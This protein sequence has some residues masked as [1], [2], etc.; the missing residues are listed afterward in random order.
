MH[1]IN[2]G[3]GPE[4]LQGEPNEFEKA[5]LE[6][7]DLYDIEHNRCERNGIGPEQVYTLK[8][9]LAQ[10][11]GGGNRSRRRNGRKWDKFPICVY[12]EVRTDGGTTS[13]Q[14]DHFRPRSRYKH[15][16]FKWDNLMYACRRCNKKKCDKFPE[17]IGGYVSPAD[18]YC[19]GY[20]DYDVKTGKITANSDIKDGAL[21]VRIE[22]TIFDLKLNSDGL[23][24]AR[25]G[26]NDRI[27]EK[28]RENTHIGL[29][30]RLEEFT[31]RSSPF[32]SYARAYA[33]H[34]RSSY[35]EQ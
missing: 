4:F 32:S 2:H 29:R 31:K 27:D 16:T 18:P 24:R 21:K 28:N 11:F 34:L 7:V 26:N 25:K 14:I 1:Y 33:A 12:C 10:R 15:L 35:A 9:E 6:W 3:P 17:N 23:C 20:F 30:R 13:P 22:Q 5:G 19:A 8:H